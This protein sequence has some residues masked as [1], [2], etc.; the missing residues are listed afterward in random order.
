MDR[1][2]NCPGKD[3]QGK[4][5][6]WPGDEVNFCCAPC[7][8]FTWANMQGQD[9]VHEHSDQCAWRQLA[10]VAEPVVEGE[11]KIHTPKQAPP[12]RLGGTGGPK[13]S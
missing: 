4:V 2:A 9:V 5:K 8:D 13:V 10:R 12:S 3:C 11:F 7:W 6:I 1:F